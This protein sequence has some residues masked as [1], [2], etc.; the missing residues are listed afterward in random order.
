MTD[1]CPTKSL[2]EGT[3]DGSNWLLEAEIRG[4]KREFA[5]DAIVLSFDLKVETESSS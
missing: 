2:E 4:L 5:V 3:V 1:L